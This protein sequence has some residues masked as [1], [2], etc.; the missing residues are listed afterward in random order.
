[1]HTWG[2]GGGVLHN[3]GG[4]GTKHNHNYPHTVSWGAQSLGGRG[5]KGG[6]MVGN[7]HLYNTTG[8]HSREEGR[9]NTPTCQCVSTAQP[10]FKMRCQKKSHTCN[11]ETDTLPHLRPNQQVSPSTHTEMRKGGV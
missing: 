8:T 2:G 1:M 7:G 11:K 6:G 10:L 9:S 5:S 4:G 3:L